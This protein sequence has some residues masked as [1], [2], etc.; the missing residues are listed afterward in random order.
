VS[1]PM[2]HELIP[3]APM[4]EPIIPI[5]MVGSS[6]VAPNVHGARVIHGSKVPIAANEED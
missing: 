5:C 4:H 2:I 6:L 1:T 3:P